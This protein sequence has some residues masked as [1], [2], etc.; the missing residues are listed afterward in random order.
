MAINPEQSI[1]TLAQSFGEDKIAN[2]RLMLGALK[3]LVLQRR[4]VFEINSLHKTLLS[5]SI[6]AK[7]SCVLGFS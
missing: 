6:Y 7:A 5:H 3:H 2:D 4:D 1:A